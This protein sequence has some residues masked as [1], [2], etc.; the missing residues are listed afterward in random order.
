MAFLG[1]SGDTAGTPSFTWN[2]D[3]DT[4]FYAVSAG[5]IGLTINGLE[6]VRF[7][8][9]Y[10]RMAAGSTGI[11]FG[12]RTGASNTLDDYEEGTWTPVVADGASGTTV[13]TYTTSSGNYVKIGKLVSASF[14][15]TNIVTTTL[16]AAN[17]VFIRSLP[18]STESITADH[19]GSAQIIQLN[20]SVYNLQANSITL[21]A[22]GGQAYTRIALS[23]PGAG[24]FVTVNQLVSGQADI[25]GTLTYTTAT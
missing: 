17:N 15:V 19:L 21:R 3:T 6:A 12:G 1:L 7:T 16:T 4:G 9:P 11:Q 2:G 5:V 22:A 8:G 13:A 23:T 10:I 24:V 14:V 18:Y 25:Y 20:S